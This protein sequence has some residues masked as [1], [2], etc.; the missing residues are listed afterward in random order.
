MRVLL[1]STVCPLA[2]TAVIVA[3]VLRGI[4]VT[5]AVAYQFLLKL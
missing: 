5:D 2:A 3:F 1:V 4:Y